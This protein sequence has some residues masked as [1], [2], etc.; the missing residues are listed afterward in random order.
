M[1]D[2]QV[3]TIGV[4]G[5]S[6]VSGSSVPA[7][8][9][10]L[11]GVIVGNNLT[12]LANGMLSANA[13]T[14]T[15][16]PW[17]NITGKPSTLAGYNI[18]DSY[19]LTGNPSGFLV[20][21][22][23]TPYALTS[24]LTVYLTTATA[25]STYLPSANFSFANISGK[26]STLGGYGISD[27]LLAT[28]AASTYLSI[29]TA[30]STY[31]TTSSLSSYLLSATA[32]ST[33]ALQA[34]TIATGTGLT[35][36]GALNAS[37]T[38]SLT[39]TAVTPG[40]YGSST[41]V[42]VITVDAQGRI[43]LASTVAVSGGGGGLSSVTGSTGITVT[44]CTTAPVVSID[45]T[46]ATLTGTQTLSSKTL[47]SPTISGELFLNSVS[48]RQAGVL[49]QSGSAAMTAYEQL[50]GSVLDINVATDTT[51]T[52]NSGTALPAAW[53]ITIVQTGLGKI[54]IVGAGTYSVVGRNGLKTAGQYAVIGIFQTTATGVFVVTGD[55][56]V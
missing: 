6:G 35:G 48:L 10:T 22:S 36:G 40:V 55:T 4:Q 20:S 49:R 56:I 47:A 28:T 9:T 54:T 46:V 8:T 21:S 12:V 26:P 27:G 14:V 43:T 16:M 17:G 3:V 32:A 30:A 5:P 37:R 34:T 15:N 42:P 38:L 31:A 33:Y 19:P 53:N 7:T 1:A 25:A 18:T 50:T 13:A 51:F 45:S 29:T 39:N 52:L 23:L 24:S 11:G 41:L 2:I 44:A